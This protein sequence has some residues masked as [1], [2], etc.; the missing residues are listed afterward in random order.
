[1]ATAFYT[2]IS[3]DTGSFQYDSVTSNTHRVIADLLDHKADQ[4]LAVQNLYQSK[5]ISQ[6]KLMG[7]AMNN[8]KLYSCGQV[9]LVSIS[10]QDLDQANASE[11]DTEGIVEMVRNIG[12]V[13]LAIFLKEVEEGVKISLRSKSQVDCT[14]IAEKFGGGGHIRASGAMSHDNLDTTHN[15]IIDYALEVLQ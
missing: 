8:L 11:M 10:R 5:S 3:S 1:M 13:E 4:Q 14:K 15:K 6:M 12:T 2:A 9:G 7:I